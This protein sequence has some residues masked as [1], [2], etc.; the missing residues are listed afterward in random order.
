MTEEEVQKFKEGVR[1]QNLGK[2]LYQL[3]FINGQKNTTEIK[4][5]EATKFYQTLDKS[6]KEEAKILDLMFQI[7]GTKITIEI[8]KPIFIVKQ[9]KEELQKETPKPSVIIEKQIEKET[10]VA[11]IVVEKKI[12]I[13]TK[14]IELPKADEYQ[15]DYLEEKYTEAESSYSKRYLSIKD[16][17]ENPKE[18]KF[19]KTGRE[20]AMSNTLFVIQQISETEAIFSTYQDI[21]SNFFTSFYRSLS[22]FD[23]AFKVVGVSSLSSI[24]VKTIKK[25]FL[26]KNGE[27]WRVKQ[28]AKIEFQ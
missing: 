20:R 3:N 5:K 4:I 22:D 24:S 1:L 7:T 2:A 17:V 27:V 9:V 14:E 12:E 6:T 13:D 15:N 11:T 28:K 19:L 18:G 26:L 25:G 8:E 16:V 21:T 10:K 23:F